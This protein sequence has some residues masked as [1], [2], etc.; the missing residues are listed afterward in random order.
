[1]L[2]FSGKF[3][4]TVDVKGRINI[5]ADFRRQ[6]S[7]DSLNTFHITFGP[8]SS[9]FVYPREVFVNIA[10]RL[11]EKY[12]SL[13]T[14]EEERRFFLEMMAHAQPARCD[15]QGRIIVPKTHL[16]YSNIQKEVLIIGAVTKLEFWN[17]DH[18]EAFF[19]QSA[20][21]SQ[22]RVQRFGGADRA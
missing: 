3:L 15:G 1:M 6:L 19:K 8:D 17:P 21:T 11:E 2:A 10:S 20:L 5:P 9:L 22:D 4:Y 12:G 13:A 14:P 7:D 16:E 18:Y